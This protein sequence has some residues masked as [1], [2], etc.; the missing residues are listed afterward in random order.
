MRINKNKRFITFLLLGLL[1]AICFIAVSLKTG[2]QEMNIYPLGH[3]PS[4]A[5]YSL[6]AHAQAWAKI[7]AAIIADRNSK[8]GIGEHLFWA[9][10]YFDLSTPL[11]F[12][13]PKAVP[14]NLVVERTGMSG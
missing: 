8:M 9:S 6:E 14:P 10:T 11:G 3:S 2:T 5:G 4:F 13:F 1:A 12:A 7:D